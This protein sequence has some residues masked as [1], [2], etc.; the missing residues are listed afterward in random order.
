MNAVAGPAPA[1]IDAAVAALRAG[2]LVAFPTETVY[3][4][5]ADARNPA[6]LR[7]IYALKGRPSTHPLILHLADAAQLPQWVASVP[8]AAKALAERFWPGPLTMV[9]PR[10]PGVPDELTGGQDSLAVRVPSHPVAQ[11]LLSAFGGGIAAPS[12]NRYGRVSP[13]RAEHV[14]EEFSQALL[15]L[16][17]GECAVGLESTIVSLLEGEPRLLRPGAITR[18]QIEAIIGPVL[19][20]G[21]PGATPRVPGSTAQHYAPQTPIALVAASEL[22]QALVDAAARGERVAVMARSEAPLE[23]AA[24]PMIHWQRM[25]DASADYGQQLYAM[26]RRLDKLGVSRILVERVPAGIEWDAIRD[27][28]GR[29]AATFC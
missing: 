14:R 21:A 23:S 29:A 7:K 6:A 9:L 12:A 5:G 11:A 10:A 25:P 28:L 1:E 15:V 19:E 17:G 22:T 20:V 27:R 13:T 16:E 2:E 26:L 18:A 8:P 4:L 24:T 3:G